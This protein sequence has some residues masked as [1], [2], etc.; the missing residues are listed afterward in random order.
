MTATAR[1]ADQTAKVAEHAM[2]DKGTTVV[3]MAKRPVRKLNIKPGLMPSVATYC[4]RLW[5]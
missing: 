2:P 5:C 3:M 1:R 4:R